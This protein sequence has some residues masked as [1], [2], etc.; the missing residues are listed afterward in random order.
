MQRDLPKTRIVHFPF[1]FVGEQILLLRSSWISGLVH[2]EV[3][4]Q[5][6]N[7][8]RFHVVTRQVQ[9]LPQPA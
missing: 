8:E 6:P 2:K 4:G 1:Q 3:V 5:N 9:W 7:G